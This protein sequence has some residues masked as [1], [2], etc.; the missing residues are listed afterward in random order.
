M[1]ARVREGLDLVDLLA[2]QMRR[3]IGASV[4]VDDLASAGR[5]ALV[6][7]A[8]GFDASRGVPFRR[9]A[10]LR[11][12]G[13]MIDAARSTGLPRRLY[14]KLRAT[15]AADRLQEATDE[16]DAA[17]P[18]ANAEEADAR[19]A[20]RLEGAALAM[21]LGLLRMGGQPELEAARDAKE[22]PEE[23]VARAELVARVRAAIDARPDNERTLLVRHYFEDVTFEEAAR[24][25][26]LSKSWASRLHARAIEAL[27]RDLAG[28][29][30]APPAT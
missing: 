7:A 29:G 18:P 12:R 21:A 15:E 10:N 5:E 16:A 25:I 24:E 30:G 26:G 1:L 19:L 3:Q 8:R 20:T 14:E 22:S 27:A 13:A 6:L 23:Q 2:R 4:Q 9:W 28:L 11:V 17:R